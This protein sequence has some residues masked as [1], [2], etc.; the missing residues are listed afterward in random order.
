MQAD[1]HGEAR[2]RPSGCEGVRSGEGPTL[3]QGGD[4]R[5]AMTGPMEVVRALT[6]AERITWP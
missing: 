1:A 2:P 6:S 3:K 4:V 5:A